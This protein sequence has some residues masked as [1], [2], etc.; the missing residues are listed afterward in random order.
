[1]HVDHLPDPLGGEWQAG[2]EQVEEHHAD[3]VE[4]GLRGGGR[5]G[6][7]FRGHVR[8]RA[9]Q[10]SAGRDD[11]G[12]LANQAEVGQ[13]GLALGRQQDVGRLDVTMDQARPVGRGE[14]LRRLPDQDRRPQGVERPLVDDA[15]LEADAAGHVLHLDV[16]IAPVAAEVVHGH[17]VRVDQARHG[18]GLAP[19]PLDRLRLATDQARAQHLDRA[20]PAQP[21]V[22]A[23][24]DPAHRAPADDFKDPV[25]AQRGADQVVDGWKAVRARL[26]FGG[27]RVG[28]IGHRLLDRLAEFAGRVRLEQ[29]ASR[30]RLERAGRW[31]LAE[32]TRGVAT[33]RA[34]GILG[35]GLHHLSFQGNQLRNEWTGIESNRAG[36]G[37]V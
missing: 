25:L 12:Q 36:S 8:R 35:R 1:M 33:V 5:A 14:T 34:G 22:L 28:R 2:R 32:R 31:R 23:P 7:Q 24:I 15:L 21:P 30:L 11:L 27:L 13:L 6:K 10:R 26:V 4:V 29:R 18:A 37:G 17:D 16:V 20:G 9:G 3:G 19:E